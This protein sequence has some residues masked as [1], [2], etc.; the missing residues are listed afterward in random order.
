[1]TIN[2][3]RSYHRVNTLL[4]FAARRI[5]VESDDTGLQ[6]RMAKD[7]LVIDDTTPLPVLDERMNAWLNILNAKLDYL[8]R[9]APSRSEIGSSMAFEPVNISG[10]GMMII[11]GDTFQIGDITEVKMVMEVYPAKILYLYGEVIRI[12]ETP[13][14]PEMHMVGIKFLG[15]TDEVKNEILKFEFNKHGEKLLQKKGVPA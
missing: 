6:C 11:T 15:M 3:K 9:L 1:M 14:R 8:I 13:H 10:S 7:G 12:E 5:A 4:P 2:N